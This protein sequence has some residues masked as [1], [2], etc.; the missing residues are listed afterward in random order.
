MKHAYLILAH[1]EFDLLRKLV[2]AIDDP[3]NDI[4]IHF[5]AK[6]KDIPVIESKASRIVVLSERID[7][8]WGDVS[9]VEAEYELF[10]KAF[11]TAEYSYYHLLSGVDLPL[12]NQDD[13]HSFFSRNNGKEFIGFNNEESNLSL[14]RK[15]KRY[16]FFAKDLRYDASIFSFLK[17]IIRAIALRAQFLLRIERNRNIDFKKGTQWISVT[18]NFVNL[19]LSEKKR[20]LDIFIGTFCPDEIFIQTICWNSNYRP[21]VYNI[22]DEGVSCQRFIGWDNNVIIEWK[23]EDFE[24]L[25][26]SNMLFARKFSSRYMRL[27]DRIVNHL[28]NSSH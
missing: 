21:N 14:N 13:I 17:K 4:F 25:M 16:H 26:Q 7:V 1:N 3:R 6:V 9:V 5:D 12:K 2:E 18:H 10:E 27:V 24:K 19:V 20:T 11:K 28:G 15:V 23:D 22:E 8:R